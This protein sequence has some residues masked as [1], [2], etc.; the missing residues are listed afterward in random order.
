M[1]KF[2]KSTETIGKDSCFICCYVTKAAMYYP[3]KSIQEHQKDQL[4]ESICSLIQVDQYRKEI[5]L[6]NSR[7]N[8]V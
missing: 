7:D 2:S 8:F 1:Q 3:T 6:T 4:T 5:K